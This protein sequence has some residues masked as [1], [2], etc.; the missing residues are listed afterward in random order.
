M[1]YALRHAFD[2]FVEMGKNAPKKSPAGAACRSFAARLCRPSLFGRYAP[3]SLRPAQ[4]R[5]TSRLRI[6][7]TN[8]ALTSGGSRY[9]NGRN[10]PSTVQLVLHLTYAPE[11]QAQ[12][13]PNHLRKPNKAD[14]MP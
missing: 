11:E 1:L 2:S 10:I 8:V 4:P 5:K 7:R 3:S 6:Y 12:A 9:K 13:M 14:Y